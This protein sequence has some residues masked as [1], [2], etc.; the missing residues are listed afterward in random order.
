MEYTYVKGCVTPKLSRMA[1]LWKHVE[2]NEIFI[3][4]DFPSQPETEQN[5]SYM[6]LDKPKITPYKSSL[7]NPKQVLISDFNS[8][9]VEFEGYWWKLN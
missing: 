3:S 8:G 5:Y 1:Y 4:F 2:T 7:R 6:L 9:V